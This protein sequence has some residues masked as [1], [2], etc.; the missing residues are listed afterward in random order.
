[1]SKRFTSAQHSY[2]TYEQEALGALEALLKWKD[3]LIGRHLKLV[4]D[5]KALTFLSEKKKLPGRIERW[6]EYLSRFDYEIIHVPGEQN[7]VA[8]ALSRYYSSEPEDS[9]PP[10][11]DLVS[12]DMRLNPDGE[13]LPDPRIAEMRAQRVTKEQSTGRAPR[14]GE[15]REPR[16]TE[17]DE[18][19]RHLH[20][21]HDEQPTPG[22]DPVAV[23]SRAQDP[24]LPKQMEGL[25]DLPK[26]IKRGQR[27]DPICMKIIVNPS[28]HKR[29]RIHNGIVEHLTS[30]DRWVT[31]VPNILLGR[32]R[33]RQVVI[34]QAHTLVGHMGNDKTN[35]YIRRWFWW[36][37]MSREIERYCASCGIC[38]ASKDSNQKPQGLLHNLL[39]PTRPWQ[40]ISMDFV[41]PFP[42]C[43]GSDYLWVV[44]CRFTGATHLVPIQTTTKALELAWLFLKE[45]V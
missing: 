15:V 21:K 45:I 35:R 6:I 24:E 39:I 13:T 38:Q 7:K 36:P 11:Y 10:P 42:D 1:M 2:F 3:K 37:S 16:R 31:V 40:S 23:G 14:V 28:H 8:D 34:D 5:H 12:A 26:V 32:H 27:D 17:A 9:E 30:Q 4:T 20:N 19:R 33:L 29:F 44:V 25:V 43:D 18:I 22:E 41:G